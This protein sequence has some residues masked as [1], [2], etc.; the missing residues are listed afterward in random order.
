MTVTVRAIIIPAT[1]VTMTAAGTIATGTDPD[2]E[3]EEVTDVTMTVIDRGHITIMTTGV[4]EEV[5][6]ITRGIETG[7]GIINSLL[8]LPN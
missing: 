1:V 8:R 4:T 2:M 3:E 7:D 5:T 6:T